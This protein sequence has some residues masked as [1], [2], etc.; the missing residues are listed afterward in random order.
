VAGGDDFYATG[1]TLDYAA[2]ND[3]F[4][5]GLVD[6][7]KWDSLTSGS[8]AITESAG[9]LKLD[10]GTS[11]GGGE[12]SLT[13]KTAV[14]SGA[15]SAALAASS[16]ATKYS[17]AES[18]QTSA[19]LSLKHSQQP[20]S[21]VSL[22][23]RPRADGRVDVS[24]EAIMRGAQQTLVQE[25]WDAAAVLGATESKR[26]RLVRHGARVLAVIGTRV[27]A[28]IAG[29]EPHGQVLSRL[30]TVRP[31][32]GSGTVASW[33]ASWGSVRRDPVVLFGAEPAAVSRVVG[34][35]VAFGQTPAVR[36]P[37]AVQVTVPGVN[38]TASFTFRNL[39]SFSVYAKAGYSLSVENEP[40]LA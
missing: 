7:S 40:V 16:G 5:D 10:A 28:D 20:T 36:K 23:I 24:F 35:T 6:A 11:A 22:G 18:T 21:T 9:V 19:E 37:G 12:A 14:D 33:F 25:T 1:W 17:A 31:S 39:D 26:L 8:G 15:F 3:G 34:T 13:S 4:D 27:L 32:I 38:G 2:W 30:R 29:W